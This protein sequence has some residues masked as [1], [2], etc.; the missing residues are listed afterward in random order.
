MVCNALASGE[1]QGRTYF[2]FHTKTL[3]LSPVYAAV[4]NR[5]GSHK[6]DF[7]NPPKQ[8]RVMT[9]VNRSLKRRS[10][11]RPGGEVHDAPDHHF[12]ENLAS[13]HPKKAIRAKYELS[14]TKLVQETGHGTEEPPSSTTGASDNG[15]KEESPVFPCPLST[16]F[17]HRRQQCCIDGFFLVHKGPFSEFESNC[18]CTTRCL[19]DLGTRVSWSSSSLRH[20]VKRTEVV[21]NSLARVSETNNPSRRATQGDPPGGLS[22]PRLNTD[23]SSRSSHRRNDHQTPRTQL[24]TS[25]YAE[26]RLFVCLNHGCGKAFSRNEELTRHAKIHSGL[27]PFVCKECS[28]GFGRRDHLTKHQRTHLPI[29]LKRSYLCPVPGCQHKLIMYLA[30]SQP[31]RYTRSDAL[32]RHQ[33]SFHQLKTTQPRSKTRL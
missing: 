16:D 21:L 17:T 31:P 19:I 33:W 28:K 10:D 6:K 12:E 15:A 7:S 11:A 32:T 24:N 29:A 23:D 4:E 2:E 26:E 5:N 3:P 25:K 18:S 22:L 14:V 9:S 1:W 27:R 13:Q 8:Q 30:T 20:E